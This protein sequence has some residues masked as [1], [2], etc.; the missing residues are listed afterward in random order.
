LLSFAAEEGAVDRATTVALYIADRAGYLR[1]A[2]ITR[3]LTSISKAHQSAGFEESPSSSHRFVVSETLKGIR[4]SIGT[5]QEGKAPPLTSD[6][7]RIVACSF[8]ASAT[9]RWST[10]ASPAPSAARSL[11]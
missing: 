2:T 3:R 8:Q 10:L 5:A 4:R 1:S 11:P 6:I 7:R 9:G